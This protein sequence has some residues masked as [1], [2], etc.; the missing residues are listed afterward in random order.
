MREG[1]ALC[2]KMTRRAWSTRIDL[3]LTRIRTAR[4]RLGVRRFCAAFGVH[5]KR[6]YCANFRSE[7]RIMT[8][9]SLRPLHSPLTT[10]I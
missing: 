8:A 2:V 9:D 5:R 4:Q 1:H 7:A 10:A 3:S 6:T